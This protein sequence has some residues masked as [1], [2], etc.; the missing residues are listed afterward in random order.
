MYKK[1]RAALAALAGML[2]LSVC[3]VPVHAA[4]PQVGEVVDGTLLT[5]DTQSQGSQ[6][7]NWSFTPEGAAMPF[8]QY[9]SLG[10]SLLALNTATTVYVEGKTKCHQVCNKVTVTSVLQKLVNGSWR[11]VTER[12]ATAYNTASANVYSTIPVS[13]GTHYRVV[14]THTATKNGV[15]ETGSSVTGSVYVQ[16]N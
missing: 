10:H 7:F 13:G 15:T 3:A 16:K 5:E 8:G 14:S 6:E 9:Y 11:Y 12:T 1:W 4:G 2:C